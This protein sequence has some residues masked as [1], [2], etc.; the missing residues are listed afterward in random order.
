LA[1]APSVEHT[2]RSLDPDQPVSDVRTMNQWAAKS[3]AQARFSSF[4][5]AVFAA[6]ALLLASIGIYGVMSYIVRQRTHEIGIRLAL[7]ASR[8]SIVGSVMGRTLRLSSVGLVIGLVAAWMLSGLLKSLLFGIE[9]TDWV[10]YFAISAT[11]LV[12][13]SL[14]SLLPARRAMRADPVD[15]L[16][17]S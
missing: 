9:H 14:A 10:T 13:A 5:L 2:I 17:G 15:A 1:L 3:I 8:A 7:G 12:V 16:R 11:L 6:V 4:L